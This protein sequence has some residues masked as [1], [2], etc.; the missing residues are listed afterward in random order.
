MSLPSSGV[1]WKDYEIST[2][3]F[4]LTEVEKPD[5]SA[6]LVH[7]TGKN[8]LINILRGEGLEGIQLPVESGFIKASIPQFDSGTHYNSKVVCFTES[9]T[10]ALDF[11]RYRSYKRWNA[12]QRYGIGFSKEYL[13]LNQQVRPVIYTDTD[14]NRDLLNVIRKFESGEIKCSDELD[15]LIVMSLLSKIK[16]L[17]FPLL[18]R[19]SKQGYMWEREW[20]S[21]NDLGLIFPYAS[22]RLI[23]C[24]KN[25]IDPIKEVLRDHLKHV[26]IVETWRE[27]DE[28]TDYLKRRETEYD[29]SLVSQVKQLNDID[30][31]KELKE[32]N[33]QTLNTL[34]FYYETFKGAV[35]SLENRD[36]G[37]I[38]DDFASRSKQISA[39]IKE[40]E[41]MQKIANE[42]K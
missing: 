3:T 21:T 20:R 33:D 9:P 23:C 29:T 13:T 28:I 1:R 10:F 32:K 41:E 37:K 35:N 39:R 17:L 31:L 5:I 11:F 27:Y 34:S 42:K 2:P 40:L 6:F 14:T 22:I 26:K 4:R 36:I 16:G 12:D 38:L 7:L 18:E 15:N 8:S 24:P 19:E 30:T 25:E